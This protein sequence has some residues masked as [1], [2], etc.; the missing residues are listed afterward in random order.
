M[1][2]HGSVCSALSRR[3]FWKSKNVMALPAFELDNWFAAAEGKYD[4]SISH[5][6]CEPAAAADFMNADELA[7]L[8]QEPLAYA[9]FAGCPELRSTIAEQY[10]SLSANDVVVLNGASEAIYTLMQAEL[11]AGDRVV[12]QW[13][14]FF[15]LHSIARSLG[16]E[17]VPWKPLDD[18]RC[19]YELS[20][21]KTICNASTR[22]IIL[23]QP[24]NPTGQLFDEP[25]QGRIIEIAEQCGAMLLCDEVFRLLEIPP[26][27]ALP[28]I[29]DRYARGISIS[30]MSKP[31]GLGGLRI[32]WL[33]TKQHDVLRRTIEFRYNTT[34]MTNAP[35]QRIAN[36]ALQRKDLF[37]TRNREIIV[38]NLQQ[39]SHF[40]DK[41]PQ[42]RLTQPRAGSMA[43]V[44]QEFGITSTDLCQRALEEARL[45]IVPGKPLGMSDQL[46]RIGLGRTDLAQGLERLGDFLS[47]LTAS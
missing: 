6:D 17:I 36:A 42:L 34:E 20:E 3:V 12:V 8:T 45:F 47:N 21:L 32:G 35:C 9:P 2:Q 40:V 15:T 29:A 10:E 44:A 25:T 18:F 23:N 41:F 14:L 33:A 5:S 19:S 1:L 27:T 24:H 31:F 16:C 22:L 37:L 7:A 30:G 43:I 11:K 28:A 4:L 46:L 26:Q 39:L 38:N 13:P